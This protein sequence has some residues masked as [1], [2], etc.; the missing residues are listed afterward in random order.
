MKVTL[1]TISKETGFSVSTISRA[2]RAEGRISEVNRKKIL[3]SAHRL[4]Y[5][6]PV[7]RNKNRKNRLPYFALITDYKTGEFY[8]S[9]CVG[10]VNAARKKNVS[11]SLFSIK[12]N[13]NAL[14]QLINDLQSLG[15][16]GAIIFVPKLKQ[17]QYEH[18]LIST[19]TDFPI[20]SCSNIDN[21]VID[22]VTFDAYQGAT[23][24]AKHFHESGFEKFGI[25]EGPKIMPESRFRTNG[26]N[27]FIKH[28]AQKKILWNFQGDYSIESGSDAFYAYNK[29]NSKNKPD[30]IF[31]TNDAMAIGFMEAA[32]REGVS[33]PEDVAIC[34]YDNLPACDNHF[35]KI[36][37]VDTNYEL[38]AENTID[39]LLSRVNKNKAH[40]GIVSL[41]PVQLVVRESSQNNYSN[42]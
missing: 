35:P 38:L 17:E 22:T 11:I 23:L 36:S 6:L 25:I 28:V 20:I 13:S 26:F 4:G 30:A 9:F 1:E 2:L 19:P 41:V 39:N 24:V 12:P 14:F 32:R 7:S 8:S 5:P 27:D 29:L 33:I 3:A 18:L 15:F 10:F 16:A 31:V 42:D 40:Q 34:G 37:S 21:S